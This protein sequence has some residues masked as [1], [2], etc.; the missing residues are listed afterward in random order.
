MS[1]KNPVDFSG[2]PSKCAVCESVYHWAKDCPDKSR[3]SDSFEV[4][5]F[6]REIEECYIES[7]VGESLNSAILDSGCTRRY[8]VRHGSSVI[9][10]LCQ[11]KIS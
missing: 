7:F 10:I 1:K 4:E 11:R 5:L 8:A 3:E 9:K 6:C 2:N